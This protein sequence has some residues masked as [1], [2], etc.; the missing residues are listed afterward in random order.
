MAI[1]S[2]SSVFYMRIV[3]IKDE[4]RVLFLGGREV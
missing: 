4:R 2:P 3:V 1:G